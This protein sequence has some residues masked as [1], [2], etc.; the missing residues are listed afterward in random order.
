[1]RKCLA[2]AVLLTFT[3]CLAQPVFSQTSDDLKTI[4]E[5]INSLKEGQTAIQKDLQEIKKLLASRP[6]PAAQTAEFKEAVLNIG[7]DPFKG[8]KNAKLTLVEFSDFQC[9]FCAKHVRETFTKIDEEYVKT[10]KIKYVFMD[11]PLESL[12]PNAFKA[13]EA[14]NCA[15]EQGKYWEMHDILFA[16]NKALSPKDLTKHAE[17]IGLDMPKFQECLDSGKNAAEIRKDM[18]EGMGAGVKGTPTSFLGLTGPD[19]SKIKVTKILRGAI[20]Y[21]NFKEAIEGVISPKK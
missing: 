17:A 10:G 9:P 20:P 18:A 19:G 1:M 3:F 14:A 16:N 7:D 5:E 4:R 15:G 13:A 12:H 11:F 6:A 8:D 21:S 2:L